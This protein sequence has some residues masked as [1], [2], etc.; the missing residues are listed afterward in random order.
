MKFFKSILLYCASGPVSLKVFTLFYVISESY[1]P[2][3]IDSKFYVKNQVIQLNRHTV[4]N[5]LQQDPTLGLREWRLA[6]KR[7][8]GNENMSHSPT[9]AFSNE[10]IFII[11]LII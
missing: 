8:I 9:K 7:L 2:A 6:A 11:N 10:N 5:I 3:F 1:I 4:K